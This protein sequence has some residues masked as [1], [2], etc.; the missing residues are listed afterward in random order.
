MFLRLAQITDQFLQCIQY[1]LF[2]PGQF[3]DLLTEIRC[4]SLS[5][6]K[7]LLVMLYVFLLFLDLSAVFVSQDRVFF[8]GSSPFPRWDD[9]TIFIQLAD[10]SPVI[11]GLFFL[12]VPVRF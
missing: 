3:P 7:L 11:P 2:F 10:Q 12:L 8:S 1:L 4:F 9:L 5:V 6:R